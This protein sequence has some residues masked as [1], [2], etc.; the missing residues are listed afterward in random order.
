MVSKNVL[1]ASPNPVHKPHSAEVTF[2]SNLRH[3]AA[4]FFN[5]TGKIKI[6]DFFFG[7]LM[8]FFS[9]TIVGQP[10]ATFAALF[11]VFLKI[12]TGSKY[13][14][15]KNI[16][17]I[18]LFVLGLAWL[19]FTSLMLADSTVS[20]AIQRTGRI[21][22]MVLLA[23]F[24]AERRIDLKSLLFGLWS[25]MVFNAIGWITGVAPDRYVGYLSGWMNDKNVAGMY[26]A[27]IPLLLFGIL[28][29][30]KHKFLLL[31]LALPFLWLTGSRTSIGAFVIGIAWYFLANRLNFFFKIIL[32]G[33]VIWVFEWAQEKFASNSIFGD[34][35]GTDQLRSLIDSASWE[36]VQSTPWYGL[37]I[38]EAYARLDERRAYLFH[39][40]FWTL[41]VE[42][43]IIWLSLVLVATIV[44]IFVFRQK[45]QATD[46]RCLS[47]EA[48]MV[49]LFICSWRL[50]EV[51]L[52]LP[53][54]LALGLA[55]WYTAIPKNRKQYKNWLN[56]SKENV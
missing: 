49:A 31:L 46:K 25:G 1:T 33:G 53:W 42:G 37:G 7:F 29:N 52:T 55:L 10:L 24:I 22:A 56:D 3:D 9:I 50:G 20:Q 12:F 44:T 54:A 17:L 38:G 5:D 11:F 27:I 8:V 30:K 36:K 45:Q 14:V 2:A 15:P 51:M 47:A 19:L 23:A 4:E 40:S 21:F 34:R 16:F 6:I 43:G 13:L 39:N 26:Y 35:T 28:K 32:G 48:A 41:L 18:N